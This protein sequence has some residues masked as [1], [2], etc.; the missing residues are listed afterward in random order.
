MTSA[1]L[2]L[3]IATAPIDGIDAYLT[4]AAERTPPGSY[5][6]PESI[7][8]WQ[9]KDY[10]D[11]RA[12]AALDWDLARLTG[13]SAISSYG[14]AVT[15][16]AQNEAEE[17]KVF[18]RLATSC[19][20]ADTLI[21]YGARNFDWPLLMR[22]ARY[23]GVEF[24]AI[25]CDRFKSPHVDLLDRLTL[26]DPSRRKSLGWYVRRLGWTDL[27]KPLSGAEEAQ[28]P[29]T[30]RWDDLA[31]SLTHDVEATRRLAAWLGVL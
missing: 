15:F 11:E 9:A 29:V 19:R 14:Q 13:I 1:W 5:S 16:V 21:G 30:G 22:R 27:V 28:V 8:A 18:E 10:A 23:L 31:A 20:Q 6:K 3:D 2:I 24:P 12:R 7:A 26:H 25:N 17:L 4:P